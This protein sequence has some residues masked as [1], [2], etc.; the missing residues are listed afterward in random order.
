MP[1]CV[2]PSP[3]V[4]GHPC[5]PVA[6]GE[7]VPALALGTVGARVSSGVGGIVAAGGLV[8]VAGMVAVA[9]A[10]RVAVA[11]AGAVAVG[12]RVGVGA[13]VGVPLMSQAARSKTASRLM[14]LTRR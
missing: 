9:G 1:S 14:S 2:A 11:G 7:G 8:G 3:M 13:G 10:G 12:G 4:R 6:P 5:A